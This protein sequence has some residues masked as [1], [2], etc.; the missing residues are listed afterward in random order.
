MIT[1][2]IDPSH[3]QIEFAV[4][5]MG[6]STVRGHFQRFSGSV[7]SDDLGVP[8]EIHVDIETAS[9]DTNSADRDGHLRSAD[10]FDAEANPTI[11]FRSTAI[12]T[13]GGERYQIDGNLTMRGVTRSVTLNAEIGQA[14]TDPW[15]MKR[16]AASAS[17]VVHRKEFG[18]SWNQILEAGSLLVGE[19][20]KLNL[21]VQATASA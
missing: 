10:F 19:E 7:V 6:L 5:H 12:Q 11:A 3:S 16:R 4:R 13:L 2:T 15:G 20:V 9:V 8:S 14:I 21:E 18:L 17:A 1:W